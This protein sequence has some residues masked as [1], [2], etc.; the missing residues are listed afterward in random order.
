[1]NKRPNIN[2]FDGLIE[3]V[4]SRQ[5]RHESRAGLEQFVCKTKSTDPN[6]VRTTFYIPK[7]LHRRLKSFAASQERQMSDIVIE[8]LQQ[9]ILTNEQ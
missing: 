1:M 9:W 6:Y 5:N 3:V 8:L 2:R 4:R 7:S